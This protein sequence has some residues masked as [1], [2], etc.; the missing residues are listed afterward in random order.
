MSK[1]LSTNID[2][3]L[4]Q[5]GPAWH[6]ITSSKN[7]LITGLVDFL[8]SIPSSSGPLIADDIS[9]DRAA[10][11]AIW[12]LDR[13][14]SPSQSEIFSDLGESQ[15]FHNNQWLIYAWAR[16]KS[17][18]EFEGIFQQSWINLEKS[19]QGALMAWIDVVNTNNP[20]KLLEWWKLVKRSCIPIRDDW[21]YTPLLIEDYSKKIKNN[22]ERQAKLLELVF[23][24]T[25]K[26]NLLNPIHNSCLRLIIRDIASEVP[27]YVNQMPETDKGWFAFLYNMLGQL[28]FQDI[29]KICQEA[30]VPN[31]GYGAILSCAKLL[32]VYSNFSHSLIR[33]IDNLD[34]VEDICPYDSLRLMTKLV[35]KS[36]VEIWD[37]VLDYPERG[38][39]PMVAFCKWLKPSYR[40]SL[41]P[42]FG[43][44]DNEIAS[45]AY[46]AYLNKTPR[47][48]V[49]FLWKNNGFKQPMWQ[50]IILDRHL[51]A[52]KEIKPPS[53]VEDVQ[54]V[55]YD[56]RLY[57]PLN[58]R[59]F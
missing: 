33:L 48:V 44:Y 49:N 39:F 55:E 54:S 52:P 38:L 27:E 21:F 5:S 41:F 26:F 36:K 42:Y 47:T 59:R 23:S 57:D 2:I 25:D 10:R 20:G 30:Y 3:I 19:H 9:T 8:K 18:Q 7:K 43:H 28:G 45:C 37:I 56:M 1:K 15:K 16:R 31:E 11:T 58:I 13:L 40:D 4:F 12:M 6:R 53:V 35:P 50:E 46:Q 14:V 29:S 17:K 34:T 22:R 32:W 24:G 51:F